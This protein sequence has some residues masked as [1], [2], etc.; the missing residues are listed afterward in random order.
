MTQ[1][2][3]IFKLKYD[4]TVSFRVNSRQDGLY[5]LFSEKLKLGC[6]RVTSC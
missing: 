6:L 4:I 3:L 1:T 2:Q 5:E